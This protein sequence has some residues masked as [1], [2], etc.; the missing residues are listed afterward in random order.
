MKEELINIFTL[1]F[2]D[3]VQAVELDSQGR[4]IPL[5]PGQGE[6]PIQS[7][8]AIYKYLHNP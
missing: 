6:E 4:N 1:G 5:E 3:N 7:Q 2:N 8:Q